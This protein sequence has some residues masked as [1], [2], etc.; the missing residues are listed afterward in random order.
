M[1]KFYFFKTMADKG[2]NRLRPLTG[3]KF[4]DGSTV[5]PTLNVQSDKVIRTMYP[6]GTVFCSDF[7]VTRPSY[8]EAGKIYPMGLRDDEYK[9]DEHVPNEEMRRAYEEFLGVSGSSSAE[10]LDEEE[11]TERADTLLEKMKRNV[12]LS[13][14]TIKRDGFY[15]NP[16][17]WYLLCR[18]I[19]NQVN[20][21]MIGAT[22]SGKTELVMLACKK[23]GIPCHVYDMG[24]MYDP[25]AGLLGV[26]RL[27]EGGISTFDY[28]KFSQD[29]S[30]PGVILLDELSRAPVTTNNI[31]FPCLDSRRTLPVEIAGGDDLRAIKVHEDCCFIATANVGAEYTGTMSMDRALV[32]RFF[33]L[34]LDYMPKDEE[35][36]VLIKRCKIQATQAKHIVAVANN[37]RSLY[38]K[39]EISCSLSTRETLMAGELVADGWTVLRAMELVF[40]PLFEG[41]PMEGERGIISKILMSR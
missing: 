30:K 39:Q 31:L 6:L 5:D 33:P 23:L 22:G 7:L 10:F 25:V 34:E 14:P 17:D 40:L 29:I 1:T 27:Q 13:V 37:V 8:Y 3:Q 11:D 16:D 38:I 36:R 26:H 41:T 18:N 9:M 21:M 12:D 4:E 28:S 20:T 2:R 32:N 19:T 24:S 35:E 15:V